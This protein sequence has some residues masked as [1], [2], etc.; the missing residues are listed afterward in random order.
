MRE[1]AGGTH[2]VETTKNKDFGPYRAA[3]ALQYKTFISDLF[4]ASM[5]SGNS[6]ERSHPDLLVQLVYLC[7]RSYKWTPQSFKTEMTERGAKSFAVFGRLSGSLRW[8]FASLVCMPVSAVLLPFLFSFFVLV[9]LALASADLSNWSDST[10]SVLKSAVLIVSE[11]AS[12]VFR[13]ADWILTDVEKYSL[14]TQN[15]LPAPIISL[16]VFLAEYVNRIVSLILRAASEVLFWIPAGAQN[17]LDGSVPSWVK[18]LA[19]EIRVLV[20][21]TFLTGLVLAVTLFALP[22]YASAR[23]FGVVDLRSKRVILVLCGS[24]FIDNFTIN[25]CVWLYRNP[26]RHFGFHRAW[27]HIAPDVRRWLNDVLPA[28]GEVV[29]TGH[30]LGGA[31]AEVAAFDLAGQ[32]PI[33]FVAAFGSS[34]IGGSDMRAKYKERRDRLGASLHERTWHITHSNDTIPLLP[35]SRHFEHVGKG[36]L[37]SNKGHLREG[38]RGS[39]FG[40]YIRLVDRAVDVTGAVFSFPNSRISDADTNRSLLERKNL[41]MGPLTRR[42]DIYRMSFFAETIMRLVFYAL[43]AFAY[44]THVLRIGISRDHKMRLYRDALE[45]RSALLKEDNLAFPLTM[46]QDS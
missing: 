4:L 38:K 16:L 12:I 42:S 1:I 39:I 44:Y 29:L 31:L 15:W 41:E 14:T 18:L 28:G 23:A 25:A 37:L 10:G 30:S 8:R 9:V 13:S 21:L 46:R 22:V 35:P 34:R 36:Y 2:M 17:W 32:F 24:Q 20:G 19:I 33:G 5:P 7:A 45:K 40:S 27:H 43:G 3:I 6:I 11:S 26:L